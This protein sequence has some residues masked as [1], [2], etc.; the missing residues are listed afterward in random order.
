VDPNPNNNSDDESDPLDAAPDMNIVKSDGGATAAPGGTLVYT[1]TYRNVG[2]Q[3]ATGVTLSET[4][5]VNTTFNAVAS[6]PEV[7]SCADGSPAG[8]A[9]T[10]AVG[11]VA[12]GGAGSLARFGLTVDNPL[13]AGVTQ[14]DNTAGVADD[15]A[16][17]ADPTPGDNTSTD[18][19]PLSATPDMNIVKDDGGATAAPGGVIV[20]TLSYTNA[21]DQAATGVVLSETVPVHTTFNAAASLPEVW[22]CPD[23]SPAGTAC[24]LAVG[25]VAG[26]GAGGSAHFAL[27]VVN[28]LP[29]GITQVSNTAT[30]ADDGDNGADPTPG[31]NTSTDTTPLT[32][33]PLLAAVKTATLM[34]ANSNNLADPG[35]TLEYAITITNTGDQDAAGV[36]FSDT[37]DTHTS[38]VVGSVT[39]TA[40]SVTRGNNPGDSSV[41]VNLGTLA[42][43]SGTATVTFQVTIAS[44]V[45]AGVDQV[46]N[47]GAVSGSDI[48][49]L[50][51]NTVSTPLNAAPDLAI[52]KTDGISQTST[53]A[54]LIY[55]LTIS[56]NGSQAASGVEV[57]DVIP[58]H[59]TFVSAGDGGVYDSTNRTVTWPLFDLASAASVT[60]SVS[61]QVDLVIPADVTSLVNNAAV[62]D[63]GS[64]GVDP[65]PGDNI[66]SDTDGLGR[67]GKSLVESSLADTPGTKVAV[68][69]MLT[70]EVRLSVA[71]GQAANLVLVDTL[72][73]G[74]AFAGCESVSDPDGILSAAPLAFNAICQNPVVTAEPAGSTDAADAGRKFTMN[75]GT[76]SNPSEVEHTLLVRY[77]VVVLDNAANLRGVD[78]ENKAAWTW[79][80]GNLDLPAVTVTVVE[81][82]LV[83]AKAVDQAVAV[84]GQAVTFSL[85]LSH[86]TESDAPAYDVKI[87]DVLPLGLIYV[88]G[89]LH[90]VSGQVPD[91]LNDLSA[92][93]LT[94][95]WNIF[96]Q[97]GVP[98]VLA[99]E[100]RVD[101]NAGQ[102]VVNE[103]SAVW[104]S[105]PG[106]FGTAQTPYNVLSTERFYQPGSAVNNYG[107]GSSAKVGV[108][109]LPETG[110]APG[111]TT[112]L[113]EQP[114][115]LGYH[116]AGGLWLEIPSLGVELPIVGVPFVNG[117]WDLTW[118]GEQAGYLEGTA[119]PTWNG[120]SAITAHVYNAD[121]QPGPF[122][123][124]KE[125]KYGDRVIVHGY[126]QMQIFEVRDVLRTTPND[127]SP[128]KHEKLPWV[129]LITCQEYNQAGRYY[130]WRV[131]V[132]AVLVDVKADQ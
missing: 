107:V 84:P 75:L 95:S 128:L 22:S 121:G 61:V 7:W 17:G 86:K 101:L 60:R 130:Q 77:R 122:A 91:A 57:S 109:T 32:S 11:T 115:D 39:T 72:E 106:V 125:L 41:E 85:T 9:C 49:D 66:T 16:N 81:P 89:S 82:A 47:T 42:G 2:N 53:G 14:V 10:L 92:P 63:D 37:P 13:P 100:A 19:T 120:N 110:F 5:P 79:D 90:F 23:G 88:P 123:M 33:A 4:V 83:L 73:K 59:T 67:A 62:K 131:A 30:V 116:A 21:G 20:Y 54:T 129:T 71:P 3:T 94:A 119:F 112:T 48:T 70:Y 104:S 102:S 65:I 24:T 43:L 111:L 117:A 18:S 132:R 96:R 45:A 46:E 80:G 97:D 118:L 29:A 93:L 38:L 103:A 74:L 64:N 35:E 124:L 52:V 105:L 50:T 108:P 31:D 76:V 69:E 6:L 114:A 26:G 58:D 27:S 78:L 113:A 1:L 8:T 44:P 36:V 127:L 68:G 55:Q 12:G 87:S 40:G 34:D 99:F 56:N 51:T 28:P 15:G 98:T 126:G 25:T